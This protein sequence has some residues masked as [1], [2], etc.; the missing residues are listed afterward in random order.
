MNRPTPRT[1]R[2]RCGPKPGHPSNVA[3]PRNN[4]GGS[5]CPGLTDWSWGWPVG[6]AVYF[7]FITGLTIG[8][9]DIVPRQAVA[10]ALAVGDCCPRAVA[11]GRHSSDCDRDAAK[12][13][14]FS[15]VQSATD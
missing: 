12:S 14:Y 2:C 7:T 8:Y 10:R 5:G 9:G 4:T 6:D 13:E 15:P 3:G 1:M 11:D